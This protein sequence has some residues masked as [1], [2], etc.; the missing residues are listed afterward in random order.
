MCVSLYSTM[1]V[2]S[3]K[4]PPLQKYST[5]MWQRKWICSTSIFV[6]S[7]C[8]W[9][10][11][12]YASISRSFHHLLFGLCFDVGFFLLQLFVFLLWPFLPPKLTNFASL[13]AR[14]I[15]SGIIDSTI[16]VT[17]MFLRL[18]FVAWCDD[19]LQSATNGFSLSSPVG[20]SFSLLFLKFSTFTRSNFFLAC[21][22][23]L[24]FSNLSCLRISHTNAFLLLAPF[25][26][27]SERKSQSQSQSQ[28]K[29]RIRSKK[30]TTELLKHYLKIILLLFSAAAAAA[31]VVVFIRSM[32]IWNVCCCGFCYSFEWMPLSTNNTAQAGRHTL[33]FHFFC[34]SCR[35]LSFNFILCELDF[36]S[37]P[38]SPF[39]LSSEWVQVRVHAK[40]YLHASQVAVL[41]SVPVFLFLLCF[42]HPSVLIWD[43][44]QAFF[45]VNVIFFYFHHDFSFVERRTEWTSQV[46]GMKY[47]RWDDNTTGTAANSE[48]S[49]SD[50]TEERKITVEIVSKDLT[51][52]PA[53]KHHAWDPVIERLT[54]VLHEQKY[55]LRPKLTGIFSCIPF[56]SAWFLLIAKTKP[57]NNNEPE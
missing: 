44:K 36:F 48:C 52:L 35:P 7:F 32:L 33:S 17:S 16:I 9:W 39:P 55:E 10:V 42:P 45:S 37:R 12:F 8:C 14:C 47:G 3:R 54:F 27:Q 4:K 21:C 41:V 11:W 57:R 51:S 34:S 1:Y 40:C 50:V 22:F 46:H 56:S 20:L 28:S 29:R 15:N 13:L 2:R 6:F 19:S 18:P 30:T 43:W 24:F 53:M 49:G 31:A 23:F 5:S 25:V 26:Q 38:F